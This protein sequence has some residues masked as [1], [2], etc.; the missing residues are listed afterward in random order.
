ME[1]TLDN[2]VEAL[3]LDPVVRRR[4][5]MTV[6][7]TDC[8]DI[9]KVPHAG[10]VLDG[11]DGRYQLMHNGVK[12]IEG[13]YY[14]LWMTEVIRLL[15]GH[16][17]PQ[18]ERAFRE[19]LRHVP[20]NGT[21]VELG[22]FWAYYSLWF[23]QQIP[24]ARTYLIEPDPHNLEVGKRNFA[25]NGRTGEYFHF[26]IG[27][28]AGPPEP[29]ECESDGVIR[30]VP[31]TSI[32]AFLMLVGQP[33]VDV[34]LSDIQGGEAEMLE[35]A[36]DSIERGKIRFVVISTHH[37]SISGDALTHQKCLEFLRDRG[38][39][40]LAEHSVAESYSGDGLIVA[41][42]RTEDRHIPPI[43]VSRNRSTNSLFRELEY[44]LH[45]A[46]QEIRRLKERGPEGPG[47][48]GADHVVE[49]V[50]DLAASGSGSLAD[51]RLVARRR[52][53]ADTG[54]RA[55]LS[56]RLLEGLSRR[57]MSSG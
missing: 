55:W 31:M 16:H 35:G 46:W 41:S 9:S 51:R 53:G 28:Q 49:D 50:S 54:L 25:L 23:Q 57:R 8:A 21:M 14:G 34:L 6:G 52:R 2:Y 40:I 12:V 22:S 11:P 39:L 45:D 1:E 44:D 27:R 56:G 37:H 24:A 32:D 7:C 15:R 3:P 20:A 26:S 36:V 42:F 5:R 43:M 29:F 4:I 38:A 48:E 10:E 19:L 18:E 17:E 47:S 30:P 13:C 33:Y